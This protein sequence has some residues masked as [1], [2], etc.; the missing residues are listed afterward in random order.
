MVKDIAQDKQE[1]LSQLESR[2]PTRQFRKHDPRGLLLQ[3]ASQVSS[4]WPYAHDKFE[5]E[6]FIKF[7]HDWE[8]VL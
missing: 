7:S 4:C 8:E 6:I 2:L 3:Y 1:G 5:D